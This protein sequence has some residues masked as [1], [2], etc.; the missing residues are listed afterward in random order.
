MYTFNVGKTGN[1]L[2]VNTNTFWSCSVYGNFR[3]SKYSGT[4]GGE[5]TIEVPK[6]LPFASGEVIF[7]YGDERCKYPSIDIFIM[8]DC[9]IRT[10]PMYNECKIA[11]TS[12]KCEADEGKNVQFN[13]DKRILKLTF[14]EDNEAISVKVYSNGI[15]SE[16]H[17]E[18]IKTFKNGD[19]LLISAKEGTITVKPNV[20]CEDEDKVNII[21]EKI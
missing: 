5:I 16:T 10:E 19:E 9:Y 12:E 15:W 4:E 14:K 6:E 8:N 17:T 20:G 1:K 11:V 7:S 21:L 13:S 3:L 18:G 2:I